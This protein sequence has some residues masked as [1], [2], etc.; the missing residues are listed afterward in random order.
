[1]KRIGFIDWYLDE[2]HANNY[3]A[4]IRDSARNTAP[5]GS[6]RFE[7]TMAYAAVDKPG[8]LSTDD[9]CAKFGIARAATIEALVAGCDCV[10]VL[11]PDHPEK[12]EA[13][14]AVAL[15]S[16]KP[17]YIDKTFAPDKDAAIRM[18]ERAKAFGTPMYS[19]SALRYA[20]EFRSVREAGLGP[21]EVSLVSTRGP[22][23]IDNYGIHQVEMIQTLMGTGTR[24]V[25][26]QGPAETP[27]FLFQKEGGRTAVVQHLPWAGFSVLVHGQP[28]NAGGMSADAA[29]EPVGLAFDVVK[30]FWGP[31]ADELLRFFD[32]GVATVPEA[33]TIEAVAMIEAGAK[34]ARQPG[35]WIDL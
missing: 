13:L 1:M 29:K 12:H 31:F 32:T 2:W 14:A 26:M 30:D 20:Q 7:I 9:W 8:G 34:A 11:S 33:E 28:G 4:W 17:V 23:V 10:V 24:R 19:T 25:L 3:P 35:V 18:F 5:D 22:G 6:K 15:A 21:D 27:T 16:G